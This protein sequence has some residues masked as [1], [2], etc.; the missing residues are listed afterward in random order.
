MIIEL[1][2]E[3]IYVWIPE[4]YVDKQLGEL[5]FSKFWEFSTCNVTMIVTMIL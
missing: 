2:H 3:F 1:V 5:L 4:C